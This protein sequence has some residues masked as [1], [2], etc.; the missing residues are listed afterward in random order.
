MFMHCWLHRAHRR[1]NLGL[2]LAM[3]LLLYSYLRWIVLVV[4]QESYGTFQ[5]KGMAINYHRTIGQLR[6]WMGRF[7][8]WTCCRCDCTANREDRYYVSSRNRIRIMGLR[9][10]TTLVVGVFW[11]R[12]D[13]RSRFGILYD[14]S[15]QRWNQHFDS[16]LGWCKSFRC[17]WESDGSL[18]VSCQLRLTWCVACFL[19]IFLFFLHLVQH[20]HQ[21]ESNHPALSEELIDAWSKAFPKSFFHLPPVA[22]ASAVWSC[23]DYNKISTLYYIFFVIYAMSC[24]YFTINIDMF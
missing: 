16:M 21:I 22:Q 23:K 24:Y 2:L 19:L 4:R 9:P 6:S 5:T 11:D 20:P 12:D 7:R 14:A 1:T 10:T 17:T 18:P 8:C 13:Y 3:E 15:N